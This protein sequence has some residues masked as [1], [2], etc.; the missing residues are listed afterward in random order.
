MKRLG[1]WLAAG[2]AVAALAPAPGLWAGDE[3]DAG[4]VAQPAAGKPTEAKPA[5][6]PKEEKPAEK[7]ASQGSGPPAGKSE[8]DQ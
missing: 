7:P 8:P 2:A 4:K 3:K 5:E 1:S 6:K